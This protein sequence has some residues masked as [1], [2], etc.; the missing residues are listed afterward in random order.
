VGLIVRQLRSRSSRGP[1]LE[2]P[3]RLIVRESTGPPRR[4][5]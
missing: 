4:E 1:Q 2:L 3:T 5:G